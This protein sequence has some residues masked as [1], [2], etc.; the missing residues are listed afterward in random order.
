MSEVQRLMELP[1][2]ITSLQHRTSMHTLTICFY[3]TPFHKSLCVLCVSTQWSGIGCGISAC[4]VHELSFVW[5]AEWLLTAPSVATHPFCRFNKLL[6]AQT[7][8]HFHCCAFHCSL[9]VHYDIG[10]ATPDPSQPPK[11]Q[12]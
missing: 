3:S 6:R 4:F 10:A 7:R 1:P 11:I 12:T 8:P 9:K 5:V 2:R